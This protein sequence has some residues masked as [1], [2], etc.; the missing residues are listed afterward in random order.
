[1]KRRQF[2]QFVVLMAGCAAAPAFA[3]APFVHKGKTGEKEHEY[4]SRAYFEQQLG[5]EFSLC[6]H[7]A[8]RLRLEAVEDSCSG[9]RANEQ[10]HAIFEVTSG[11][12][13]HEGIYLLEDK[14]RPHMCLF[15]T[16]SERA[17][18]RQRLVATV[19]RHATA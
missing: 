18:G 13:L 7:E 4:L 3:A 5:Q 10:F 17:G 9:N 16:C 8:H 2:S 15:M 19:N 6:R 14:G 1:M 12:P 11:T